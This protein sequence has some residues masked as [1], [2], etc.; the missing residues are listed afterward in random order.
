MARRCVNFDCTVRGC[1]MSS[2]RQYTLKKRADE[3]ALRRCGGLREQPSTIH[4]GTHRP[5]PPGQHWECWSPSGRGW[6]ATPVYRHFPRRSRPDRGLSAH[7][8]RHI[9]LPTPGLEVRSR[10]PYERLEP[11]WMTST[12]FYERTEP[13]FHQRLARHRV[14]RRPPAR[15]RSLPGVPGP[16]DAD[17]GHWLRGSQRKTM[18]ARGSYRARPRLP[19]LALAGSP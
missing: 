6:N 18:P 15:A 16:G 9:P 1:E 4:G 14:R 7:Y 3:M 8:L 2:R 17:P 13:V 12:S 10:I 5:V 19:H 11:R